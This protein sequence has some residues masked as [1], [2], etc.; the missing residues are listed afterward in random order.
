M[1]QKPPQKKE[2][3]S[4]GIDIG[5]HSIKIAALS[6]IAGGK[7]LKSYNIK[8][9]PFQAKDRDIQLQIKEA[10]GE[11]DL[12]PSGV[13]LSISGPDVIVRFISLPKM[14]K[15]QLEGALVFEAEKY[16][17]FNISEVVLDCMILGDDAP[18]GGHMKVLLAAAKRAP[19]ELMVN[20]FDGL[21]ISVNLMDV[22]AFACLNAFIASGGMVPGKAT[23]MLDMGHSH[24]DLLISLDNTPRFMRQIQIGGRDIDTIIA[25]NLSVPPEKVEEF[26]MGIGEF[27]KETVDQAVLQVFD[28]VIREIQLSFGYFENTCSKA[29]DGIYCSGGMLYRPGALEYLGEKLGIEIK[30]WDPFAGI[31]TADAISRE[32]LNSISSRLAVSVGLALRG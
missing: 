6:D 29:I 32:D 9:L 25:R 22:N 17:P 31:K 12:S 10:L 30:R 24:T 23:V 19:I 2:E 1:I 4:V 7:M 8:K 14:T 3:E 26:K 5:S 21:G 16:I 27:D 11:I 15:E 20:A 13:N 28:D 18:A